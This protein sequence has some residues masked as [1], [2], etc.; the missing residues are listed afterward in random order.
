MD[1]PN[2]QPHCFRGL[3]SVCAR[4]RA[5]VEEFVPRFQGVDFRIVGKLGMRRAH[6]W[7]G[8]PSA[9]AGG[10]FSSFFLVAV[11]LKSTVFGAQGRVFARTSDG[12][13]A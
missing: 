7:H 3:L 8:D 6:K 9:R 4:F 13:A 10:S 11:Y 2:V 5:K 12:F 1:I